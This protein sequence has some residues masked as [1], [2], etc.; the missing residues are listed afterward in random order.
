LL[1]WGN[2]TQANNGE[3]DFYFDSMATRKCYLAP[4]RFYS[5]EPPTSQELDP[6]MD[7]FSLGYGFFGKCMLTGRCVLA[8]LW[9]EDPLF[10]YSEL[11]R[12]KK[13]KYNPLPKLGGIENLHMRKLI[14]SMISENPDDRPKINILEW[15]VGFCIFIL[16]PTL[17]VS[18]FLSSN[19]HLS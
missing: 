11:L 17:L 4:E 18:T 1:S 13:G 9:L 2:I 14:Q 5:D 3:F 12:Y 10:S 6:K 8:E 19:F 16:S 15:Y 7:I